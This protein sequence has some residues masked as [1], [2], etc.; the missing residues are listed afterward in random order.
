VVS[1]ARLVRALA[2]SAAEH[3]CA[4]EVS[5]LAEHGW[6]S[7]TFAGS[8]FEVKV[9]LAMGKVAEAWIATLPEVDLPMP[10]QFARSVRVVAREEAK[11]RI[12]LRVEAVVLED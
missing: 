12:V 10:R 4:A 8:R 11:G 7:A 9:A 1:G 5:L 6:A 3:G 2:R